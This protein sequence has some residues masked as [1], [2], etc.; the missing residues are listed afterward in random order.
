M[1]RT[2]RATTSAWKTCSAN[3]S[4]TRW[5][6]ARNARKTH[7]AVVRFNRA[8]HTHIQ[9]RAHTHMHLSIS[10]STLTTISVRG[11]FCFFIAEI[12]APSARNAVAASPPRTGC[13]GPATWYSIWRALPAISAAVSCPP[14]N[15]LRSWMTVCSARLIISK[16]S[17]VAPHQV[18]VSVTRQQWPKRNH[19]WSSNQ[20]G[21]N[22]NKLQQHVARI[23]W[24]IW[25]AW[26]SAKRHTVASRGRR[27]SKAAQG[28]ARAAPDEI[29]S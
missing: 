25:H 12:S 7:A 3:A 2:A 8:R 14:A 27:S 6:R 18:T 4:E 23:A 9:S 17:R 29:V 5:K 28:R 22:D 24:P 20:I 10:E 1:Q 11:R 21:D 13:D 15:S 19:K 26:T 16:R